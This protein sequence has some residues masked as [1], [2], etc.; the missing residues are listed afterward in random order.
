MISQS[1]YKYANEK[2][3]VESV[4]YDRRNKNGELLNTRIKYRSI[5]LLIV[6]ILVGIS[7]ILSNSYNPVAGLIIIILTW[8]TITRGIR[9]SKKLYLRSMPHEN[10]N[11]F[12]NMSRAQLENE[13][14][15]LRNKC[16]S[17]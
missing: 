14:Y 8:F 16:A 12:N 9:V 5:I 13:L 17:I 15:K 11:G 10:L 3:R 4:K 7:I 2:P 6:Y 1:V